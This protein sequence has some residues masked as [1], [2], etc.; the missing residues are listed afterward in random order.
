MA[1]R[2]ARP[3]RCCIRR[4]SIWSARSAPT[5]TTCRRSPTRCRRSRSC[6]RSR[7]RRTWPASS[8]TSRPAATAPTSPSTSPAPATSGSRSPTA[9]TPT[10]STPRRSP[11][12]TTSWSCTWRT[13]IRPCRPAVKALAPTLYATALGVNGV[14][15][16]DDPIQHEPTYAAALAAFQRLPP[17]RVLFDNGAGSATP[18][19]PVPGFEHSFSRFPVPGTQARSWYL[20]PVGHPG[21]RPAGQARPGVVQM[22]DKA[23]PGHRLLR[24]HRRR[25]PVGGHPELQLAA[26]PAPAPRCRSCRRRCSAT[27]WCSAP[28]RC[29]AGSRRPRRDVDLQATISEVR[30][31][32]KETFVQNGWLRAS[33]RKLD[34]RQSTLLGPVPTFRARDVRAA[35]QGP[36]TQVTVP[37]YYEGHAYRAGSRIRVTISAPERHQPI[38]ASRRRSRSGHAT[39]RSRS[40]ARCPR[41]W[42]CR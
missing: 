2:P 25:R 33:E 9:C 18:G 26:E 10:R 6:T 20:G 17:V 41:A 24:Q 3:T 31:D 28:A 21:R 32:G 14:T 16:P 36:L 42:C 38:W 12:G 4:P 15:L 29:S 35:A 19:S 11:A 22:D 27:R 39:V 34:P 23:R 30:P 40:R 7:C 37:L 5:A 13:A 8:P 1:T